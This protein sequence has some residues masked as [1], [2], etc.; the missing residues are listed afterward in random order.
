MGLNRTVTQAAIDELP[1][2]VALSFAPYTEDL[3]AWI[4][5]A[6]AAGHEV[7][8]EAPMEPFDYPNNDPGPHTLLADGAAEENGRR[9]AW[10]L[11][12]ADPAWPARWQALAF[13]SLRLL[14]CSLSSNHSDVCP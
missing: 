12:Q 8:I 2:E 10:L 14:Q 3:Q 1:P 11:S 13:R 6:R 4:D 5:R 9:L 7:L